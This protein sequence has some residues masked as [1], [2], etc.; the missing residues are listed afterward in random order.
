MPWLNNPKVLVGAVGG[1]VVVVLALSFVHSYRK[2]Q[3]LAES[4]A[5]AR[6]QAV[7]SVAQQ[8][9]AVD[10][11]ESA[12]AILQEA[13]DTLVT[14]PLRAFLRAQTLVVH[15]PETTGGPQLLERAREGLAGGVTGATLAEFQKHLQ[16]GDLE[17]GAKVMDALLRAQPDNTDLRV[18]AGHLQLLLCSAHA[19]QTKWDKAK[20][21][22]LRGRALFPR[23]RIWQTRLKLL[24]QVR[25]LPKAQQAAW[26]PLLG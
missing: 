6:A 18:R 14:D 25:A 23:D 24:E 22:L 4:K 8:S 1:L 15:Y 17:A 13:E 5:Q 11:T 16:N 10:L 21:D 20:D 12:T 9:Q 19:A 26:V 2:D 7:A 3:A